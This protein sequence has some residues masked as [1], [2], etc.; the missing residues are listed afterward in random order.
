MPVTVP[1]VPTTEEPIGPVP[2]MNTEA[3]AEA[4]TTPR[5]N[6][7]AGP[8]RQPTDVEEEI[9]EILLEPTLEVLKPHVR[10]A[11]KVG[12][13]IEYYDEIH[14]EVLPPAVD[15]YFRGLQAHFQVSI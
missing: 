4:N 14:D 11:Q 2:S 6:I 15:K 7:G 10:V 12:D 1:E 5:D 9:E 3:R 8:S 13:T